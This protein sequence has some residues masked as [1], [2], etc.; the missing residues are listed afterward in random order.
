MST[1]E[2]ADRTLE[3]FKKIVPHLR[4][5]LWWVRN[6]LLKERQRTFNQNDEHIGHPALSVRIR[7]LGNR[8]EP[9]PMLMGT[10]G[11]SLGPLGRSTCVKVMNLTEDDPHHA[12]YFGSIVEP[13]LYAVDDLLDGV[14]A[15]DDVEVVRKAKVGAPAAL[16]KQAWH[17]NRVMCPNWHKPTVDTDERL[18]L[19]NFCLSHG[20]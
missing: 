10:S 2:E 7:P 17:K 8:F 5:A 19:N 3:A 18:E 9:I 6:D 14:V 16:Q 13:G 20:M 15:K 12:S 4:G 11:N 1:T